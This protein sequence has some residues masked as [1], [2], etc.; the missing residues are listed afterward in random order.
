ME[1]DRRVVITGTGVCS[2][3]GIGVDAFYKSLK[4]G[5]CKFER[6]EFGNKS[7]PF[8]SIE[9]SKHNPYSYRKYASTAL[10]EAIKQAGID[11]GKERVGIVMGCMTGTF[12]PIIDIFDDLNKDDTSLFNNSESD[13]ILQFEFNSVTNYISEKYGISGERVTLT[14]A[15]A[16]GINVIERAKEMVQT[17]DY[18]I[19]IALSTESQNTLSFLS[20]YV[21][22]ILEKNQIRPF[23]HRRKGTAL[24]EGAGAVILESE[25]HARKRKASILAEVRGISI[26]NDVSESFFSSS[27]DGNAISYAMKNAIQLSGLTCN[28]IGY[29]NAHGTGTIMNDVVESHAIKD[30]FGDY[31]YKIP[32]NSTKSYIGHTGAA[33]G[34]LEII[35]GMTSILENWIHPT[36]GYEERDPE[37]DLNY[38]PGHAIECDV[39]HFLSNS[40]GFGGINASAVISKYVEE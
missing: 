39:T 35:A 9:C 30:V 34:I 3:I 12:S 29:I 18:D 40:I 20:L 37:C 7:L 1:K 26:V 17:G 28:D 10:E 8:A 22:R 38:V 25:T 33:A 14:N 32:I 23:D 31:A 11:V 6:I 4:N 19:C 5:E 27:T 24:G 16:T 21:L 36:L 13:A 15:C 2:S